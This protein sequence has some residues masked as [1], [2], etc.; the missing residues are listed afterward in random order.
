MRGLSAEPILMPSKKSLFVLGVGLALFGRGA[1]AQA[2]PCFAFNETSAGVAPF[3]V[4]YFGS[5]SFRFSPPQGVVANQIEVLGGATL[6]HG[7]AVNLRLVDP[8]TNTPLDPPLASVA[9]GGFFA[10]P[11]GWQSGA[12]PTAT[13]LNPFET[14]QLDFAATPGIF[15][16]VGSYPLVTFPLLCADPTSAPDPFAYDFACFTTICAGIPTQGTV[17]PKIRFRGGQCG[18]AA[19]AQSLVVGEPCQASGTPTTM[20]CLPPPI[21]GVTSTILFTAPGAAGTPL[22]LFWSLGVD[23]AGSAT[24]GVGGCPFYLEPTSLAALA[25]AGLQPLA[26]GT[27]NGFS[28]SALSVDWPAD[29][30]IAGYILGLQGAV[31]DGG[32]FPTGIPGVSVRTTN[33]IRA[34]IGY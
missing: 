24:I 34:V 1:D 14:Y 23:F 2:P 12:L 15:T 11:S 19:L 25:A 21:P 22:F 6:G 32:G 7:L 17:A 9:L 26:A 3:D 5:L 8:A 4:P 33:A 29:P 10:P 18:T 28:L 20:E 13:P 30:A 27:A 31:V 16:F